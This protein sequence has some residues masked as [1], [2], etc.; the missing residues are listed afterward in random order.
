M[1]RM[2]T[3]RIHTTFVISPTLVICSDHNLGDSICAMSAIQQ[4][5]DERPNVYVCPANLSVFAFMRT[6]LMLNYQVLTDHT[7]MHV[8]HLSITRSLSQRGRYAHP[9]QQYLAQAGTFIDYVPQPMINIHPHFSV[10]EFDFIVAPWSADEFRMMPVDIWTGLF[11]VL[12]DRF[13]LC[14]IAVI[15]RDGDPRPWHDHIGGIR[16]LYGLPLANVASFMRRARRAVITIDSGPNRLAHAA[17]IR[18]HIIL[19]PDVY[20]SNWVGHPGAILITGSRQS[21]AHA[22]IVDAIMRINTVE[23]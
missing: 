13:P 5:V 15:G 4:L 19:A 6:P 7:M 16:Y 17:N 18:N 23:L 9:I 12:Q 2:K 14:S 1:W 3:I 8:V 11:N 10:R 20:P 21:W 22:E